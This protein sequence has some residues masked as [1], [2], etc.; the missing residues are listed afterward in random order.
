MT[1]KGWIALD[2]D[3][4]LTAEIDSIPR[5]VSHYLES[6]VHQGWNILILTGRALSYFKSVEDSFSF[7]YYLAI[8]NGA[9]ILKM[10]EKKLINRQYLTTSDLRE[11]EKLHL[12]EEDMIIYSGYE[13]GDFCYFRPHK[14][15]KDLLAHLDHLKKYSPQPWKQMESFDFAHDFSFPLIKCFGNEAT[16]RK[17]EIELNRVP[18]LHASTIRDP[19]TKRHH[20]NIVTHSQSTK[21]QA[22]RSIVGKTDKKIIAAGDDRNDL[23]MFA[24]ADVRI[25]ME[26]APKDVLAVADII[27]PSAAK[28]GII[29]A[30]KQAIKTI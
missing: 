10:P 27:A 18:N 22:L 16:I 17:I 26:T 24:E 23:S 7:P 4:T 6:L 28:H 13:Q 19:V 8:Q 29:D 1:G 3:G 2:I 25:V 5:E 21:G 12:S 15:S 30:L 14:F 20:F 11:I 9:D